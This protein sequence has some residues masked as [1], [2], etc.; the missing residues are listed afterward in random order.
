MDK[1]AGGLMSLDGDEKGGGP[2]TDAG[3][4]EDPMTV[5]TL[6]AKRCAWLPVL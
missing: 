1:E 5:E 3:E 2:S 4:E 6:R